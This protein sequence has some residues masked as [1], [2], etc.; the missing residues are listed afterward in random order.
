MSMWPTFLSY[1]LRMLKVCAEMPVTP[2]VSNSGNLDR[3][4]KVPEGERDLIFSC[5]GQLEISGYPPAGHGR[6]AAGLP[7]L[8]TVGLKYFAMNSRAGWT[9]EARMRISLG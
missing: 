5:L 8:T 2:L 1:N 6:A 4:C 7:D 9:R 3:K